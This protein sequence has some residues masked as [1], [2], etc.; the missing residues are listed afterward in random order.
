MSGAYMK[1]TERD[2][3]GPKILKKPKTSGVPTPTQLKGRKIVCIYFSAS[4]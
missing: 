2:L 1:G 3:F 4:W